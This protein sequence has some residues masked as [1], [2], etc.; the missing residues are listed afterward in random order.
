MTMCRFLPDRASST[1]MLRNH[2]RGV[3]SGQRLK[4]QCPGQTGQA[5]PMQHERSSHS[6]HAVLQAVSTAHVSVEHLVQ[7]DNLCCRTYLF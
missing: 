5:V 1:L 3:A 4:K 7:F 2:S 6:M